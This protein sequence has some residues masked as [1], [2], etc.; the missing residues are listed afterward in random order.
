MYVALGKGSRK[1]KKKEG[2]VFFEIPFFV[3]VP[4]MINN[5]VVQVPL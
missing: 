5:L 2:E 4:C 1:M 3:C